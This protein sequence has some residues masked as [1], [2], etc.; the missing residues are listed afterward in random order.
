MAQQGWNPGVFYLPSVL[1]PREGINSSYVLPLGHRLTYLQGLEPALLGIRLKAS[2]WVSRLP[3]MPFRGSFQRQDCNPFPF[4]Q[5]HPDLVRGELKAAFSEGSWV[6]T[7]V[8][9]QW[10]LLALTEAHA[11]GSVSSPQS[12]SSFPQSCIPRR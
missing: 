4:A 1:C 2:K 6:S 10:T 9:A 12:G 11:P 3:E 5:L 7:V 8:T